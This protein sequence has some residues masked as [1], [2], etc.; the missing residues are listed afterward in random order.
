MQYSVLLATFTGLLASSSAAVIPRAQTFNITNFF[1]SGAP[2][3]IE[4]HYSFNVTDGLTSAY[5]DASVST[6]PMISYVPVTCCQQEYGCEWSFSFKPS[7]A[8]YELNVTNISPPTSH[9]NRDEAIICFPKSDVVT[10][11]MTDPNGDYE[12][13]NA[14]QS[15]IVPYTANPWD[16]A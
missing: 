12:Y 11:N 6:E 13:L 16:E 10:V 4:T 1:V 3:S 7:D 15:M 2:Y 8:G 9:G 5:C 14:S